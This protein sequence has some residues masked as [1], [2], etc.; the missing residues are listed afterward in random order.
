M[1]TDL[2]KFK[3]LNCLK[4]QMHIDYHHQLKH[5]FVGSYIDGTM[6]TIWSCIIFIFKIIFFSLGEIIS[7][8]CLPYIHG[9]EM[10]LFKNAFTFFLVR[11]LYRTTSFLAF[12]AFTVTNSET[13]EYWN[14]ALPILSEKSADT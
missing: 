14:K 13:D 8:S 1:D 4:K 5:I 6:Y 11:E 3:L 2:Y 9:Y 10:R 7:E 12:S